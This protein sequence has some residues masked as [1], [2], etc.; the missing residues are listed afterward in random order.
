MSLFCT[1]M[2]LTEDC[3]KSLLCTKLRGEA[4]ELLMSLRHEGVKTI[5][6]ELKDR[7]NGWPSSHDYE[8]KL[9]EFQRLPNEGIKSAMSRFQQILKRLH[10][11]MSPDKFNE[12]GEYECRRKVKQ[13]A[14]PNAKASLERAEAL[15]HS[16]TG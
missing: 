6:T 9:E 14:H 15:A 10:K 4:M 7:F 2:G 16:R 3:F 5:I 11:N 13:I 1:G 8:M 12:L